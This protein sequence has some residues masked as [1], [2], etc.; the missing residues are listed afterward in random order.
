[1][2]LVGLADKTV[3]FIVN[4]DVSLAAVGAMVL[5]NIAV[6]QR[7]VV[8]YSWKFNNIEQ[9][10]NTIDRE[11]LAVMDF[12]WHFKHML[13]DHNFKVLTDH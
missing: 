3:E 5:A 8:Y 13:P 11:I 1:M 4:T 10:Y 2:E 6:I 7:P 12:S 9:C